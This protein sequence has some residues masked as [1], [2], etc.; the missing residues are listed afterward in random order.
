MRVLMILIAW[1]SGFRTATQVNLGV[2][3]KEL[4]PEKTGCMCYHGVIFAA[5]PHGWH[6]ERKKVDENKYHLL[7]GGVSEADCYYPD[8]GYVRGRLAQP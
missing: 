1:L 7:V 8:H 3:C 2:K 6:V 5:I 4:D